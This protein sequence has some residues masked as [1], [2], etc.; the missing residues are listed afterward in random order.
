M[1][2]LAI[3]FLLALLPFVAQAQIK[4]GYLSYSQALKLMPDYAIAQTNL[5]QLRAQ[6]DAETKR[7]SE[8]FVQKYETFLATQKN[9]APVILD[10]RQSELQDLLYKNMQFKEEAQRLLAKAETDAYAPLK[11]K[12]NAALA[13]IGAE[14][15]LSF[16]LN[17]DNDALPYI[18]S[19]EGEDL[20]V[21]V[22]E[23]LS[24]GK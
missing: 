16:I 10:K 8:E 6:Y 23:A 17:T 9:L 5:E 15:G 21:V 24:K 4:F 2:K 19:A 12:L 11:A 18:N 14:K 7:A 3:L 13:K 1:K 20:T 22:A